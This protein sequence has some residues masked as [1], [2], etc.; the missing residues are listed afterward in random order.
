MSEPVLLD[1]HAAIWLSTEGQ[2]RSNGKEAVLA[3][4]AD[5]QIHISPI[6][7]WEVATLVAKGRVALTMSVKAWFFRLVGL[8][9]AVLAE[10]PPDVL[11]D[12]VSLPGL[13]PK[14]PAD[15]IL[16]AT[17]REFGLT[18]VTRDQRLLDYANEGHLRAVA[19]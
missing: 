8:E 2:L 4:A 9:G 5:N 6:S 3:A 7:A 15:R 17:A 16:A 19:C 14:D 11:I 18:L 1:T 10:M 12:S 13:P